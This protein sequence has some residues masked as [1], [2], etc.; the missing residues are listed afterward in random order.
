MKHFKCVCC[1]ACCRWPGYVHIGEKDLSAISQYLGIGVNQFADEYTRLSE[2][3]KGLILNDGDDGECI[4]L[5]KDNK[6]RINPVKPHQCKT[7]PYDWNV[8]PEIG[9]L[10]KGHWEETVE[11]SSE[12]G[13]IHVLGHPSLPLNVQDAPADAQVFNCRNFCQMLSFLGIP[14]KYYGVPGS[15]VP[16]GGEFVSSGFPTCRH[17]VYG[18]SWHKL[19]NRRLSRLLAKNI[20]H[21]DEPQIIASLYGAAQS[22]IDSKGLPVVEPMVGYDHCWAPYRVFPSYAQQ[23]VIYTKQP[24]TTWNTRFFD[25]VIPHFL[26][27]EDYWSSSKPEDY[28][29]YLGRDAEDKGIA[30][31]RQCAKDTGLE[32]RVE[33]TGWSGAAKTNLLANARAVLMPTLYVEPFGYVAIEAQMCGTPVITTDWGAFAETVIQGRTGYRCRTAAEFNAAAQMVTSLDRNDIRRSALERF[34]MTVNAPFFENYF[35]FVW[36]VHKD[37]GYYTPDAFRNGNPWLG[38]PDPNITGSDLSKPQY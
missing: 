38:S 33:H 3:R 2:D 20:V 12:I 26:N 18:N 32:L 30:L 27:P 10:C 7:F 23:H 19:Y 4:F 14:Y 1:G 37:R 6:C 11:K 21:G 16:E 17:W 34:S 36:K 29:L 22:G 15:V 25:T 31:A 5:T 13:M 24:G 28:L 9:A 8:P 35:L